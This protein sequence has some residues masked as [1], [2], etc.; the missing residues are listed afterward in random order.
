MWLIRLDGFI[1][2]HG[3]FAFEAVTFALYGHSGRRIG[4]CHGA[5]VLAAIG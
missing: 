1:I 2:A 5:N 3:S 4:D